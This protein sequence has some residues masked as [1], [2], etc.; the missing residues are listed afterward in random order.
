MATVILARHGRT[1]ANAAGVL[2][3]RTQG[4]GIDDT[5][6]TQAREA[7]TRLENVSIAKLVTS[8]MQRCLET[9]DLLVPGQQI[10]IEADLNEC[11][12]GDW[13]GSKLR[14][15]SGEALWRTVQI[16]PSSAR[17]P[18][19]E[20]LT[21]MASR[22]LQAIRRIDAEVTEENGEDAIW[23]AVSHGDII[24]AILND[25]L[26]SHLDAFQRIIISPAS[27]SIVRVAEERPYVLAM[28]ARS[29]P[30]DLGGRSEEKDVSGSDASVGGGV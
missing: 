29:G 19:G 18:N 3:G 5:G 22:A 20:S 28:N 8:P 25:A 27:L 16:Q 4:V 15:L 21:A 30:L 24:K 14:D 11:D 23:L 17:F 1:A 13:T 26:G 12:Y 6:V 7:A 2:A 10:R 9:A